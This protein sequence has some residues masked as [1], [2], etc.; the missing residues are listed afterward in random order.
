MTIPISTILL[1]LAAIAF[2]CIV[3]L[4]V[5]RLA[6]GGRRRAEKAAPPVGTVAPSLESP[7]GAMFFPLNLEA[8]RQLL[9]GRGPD[10]EGLDIQ[11]PATAAQA[12]TVSLR[13]ARIYYDERCGHAVIE[14]LGSTNG[15]FVNGRR[16]PRKN[17]LKDRWTVGLGNLTLIYRDGKSDTGPVGSIS[18]TDSQGAAS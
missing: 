10:T 8:G 16:A 12:G 5:V 17:L 2:L 1:G 15:V 18:Y 13:H 11:I 7:D 4:L 3:V 6:R 9:I 14:D